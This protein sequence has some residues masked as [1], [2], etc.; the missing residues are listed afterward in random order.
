MMV[1]EPS[2]DPETYFQ[3]I[4]KLQIESDVLLNSKPLNN[5]RLHKSKSQLYE[6]LRRHNE[7]FQ[8]STEELPRT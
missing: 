4:S 5:L 6:L 7:K 1:P 3:R 8:I 2:M